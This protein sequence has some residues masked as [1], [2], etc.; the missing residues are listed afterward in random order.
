MD[1]FDAVLKM[2]CA[3]LNAYK[4]IRQHFKKH[5]KQN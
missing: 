1:Y 4:G 5:R 3:L 2:Y